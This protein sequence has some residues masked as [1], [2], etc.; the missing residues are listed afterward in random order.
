MQP[1]SGRQREALEPCPA[2]RVL[3]PSCVDSLSSTSSS[4]RLRLGEGK[5]SLFC[6]LP[7]PNPKSPCRPFPRLCSPFSPSLT[8]FQ[9]QHASSDTNTPHRPHLR[10]ESNSTHR[11]QRWT[12]RRAPRQARRSG[13][14][15]TM[16]AETVSSSR[17]TT[18]PRLSNKSLLLSTPKLSS[19]SW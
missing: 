13:L 9:H 7:L 5:Q 11:R 4:E 15:S 12:I 8:T 2:S 16:M 10:R 14:R 18:T 19:R 17:P 3:V 1:G 6:S